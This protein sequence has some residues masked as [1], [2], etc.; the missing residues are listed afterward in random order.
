M[1]KKKIKEVFDEVEKKVDN[2]MEKLEPGEW[3]IVNEKAE[4]SGRRP[5]IIDKIRKLLEDEGFVLSSESDYGI[6]RYMT[7]WRKNEWFKLDNKTE[8]KP[9]EKLRKKFG[10]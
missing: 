5:T 3:E 2:I 1:G 9:P 7:L 6:Q 8:V 10:W 4:D